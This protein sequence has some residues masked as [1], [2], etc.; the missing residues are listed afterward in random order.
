MVTTKLDA[1]PSASTQ[2]PNHETHILSTH[3]S[4]RDRFRRGRADPNTPTETAQ[5]SKPAANVTAHGSKPGSNHT[6]HPDYGS[7]PGAGEYST[8]ADI[9]KPNH[10][11]DNAQH[12]AERG[13]DET[14][15]GTGQ[16]K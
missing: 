4:V 7:K 16:A 15:D 2:S 8:P 13:R 5:C 10:S 11:A 9:S 6:A 3:Y 12:D 1:V 14:N